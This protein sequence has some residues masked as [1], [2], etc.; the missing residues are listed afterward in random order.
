MIASIGEKSFKED[1]LRSPIPVL[2]YFWTPW[3]GPCRIIEPA[4]MRLQHESPCGLKVVRINADENF[5]LAKTFSLTSIPTILLFNQGNL[6]SRIEQVNGRED[7]I[8]PLQ[9]AL[10]SIPRIHYEESRLAVG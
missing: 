10:A 1:V 3:C 9:V 4:I 2:V 6:V 7:V 5:W 8:R